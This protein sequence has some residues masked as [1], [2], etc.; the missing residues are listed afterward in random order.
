MSTTIKY[1]VRAKISEGRAAPHPSR[2]ESALDVGI[3]GAPEES[4]L[5]AIESFEVVDVTHAGTTAEAQTSALA[6]LFELRD[7]TPPILTADEWAAVRAEFLRY[8]IALRTIAQMWDG[9]TVPE[10]ETYDDTESAY[11]NGHD[12][13]SY[14]AAKLALEA[15]AD[16]SVLGRKTAAMQACR[17]LVEAYQRGEESEGSVEWEDLDQAHA[18][19]LAALRE[20]EDALDRDLIEL[21]RRKLIELRGGSVALTGEGLAI[22]RRRREP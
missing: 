13:A 14:E 22:A 12:V 15:I 11:N 21:E 2:L 20:E 4:G 3:E 7:E 5:D 1:L 16:P 17:L 19:A 8:S 6:R 10:P 18:A 9:E